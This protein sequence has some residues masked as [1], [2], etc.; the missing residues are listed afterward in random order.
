[1]IR[2]GGFITI[3][4][5]VALTLAWADQGN[6][7]SPYIGQELRDIKALSP[8]DIQGYLAGKGVGLAKAAEL[9]HYPGPA[10]VLE[11]A[12]KLK[13][14]EEQR[15][16][17]EEIFSAMQSESKRLGKDFIERERELDRLFANR[18]I[19]N[20]T[21][22]STLE[23]IG[24][25]QTELRRVHLKAHLEQRAILTEDQVAKYDELRG[26]VGTGK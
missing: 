19:N 12:E 18:S 9:N 6:Q 25:L 2:I 22:S 5:L 13:L 21:L 26:Y 20:E 4:L 3:A 14:T 16:K 10:H 8:E 15:E 24:H 11:F 17:T 1:M 7:R 23:Q